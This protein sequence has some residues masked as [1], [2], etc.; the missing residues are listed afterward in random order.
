MKRE[1]IKKRKE[2]TNH[3]V[4]CTIKFSSDL[5][6]LI[7][8]NYLNVDVIYIPTALKI[9]RQPSTCIYYITSSVQYK[10][11]AVLIIQNA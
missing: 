9:I 7:R 1:R 4:D 6:A 2:N 10:Y 3:N 11:N 5:F 8:V